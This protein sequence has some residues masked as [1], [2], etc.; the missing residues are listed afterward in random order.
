MADASGFFVGL[1]GIANLAAGIADRHADSAPETDYTRKNEHSADKQQGAEP[2]S[3]PSPIH[4]KALIKLPCA[5]AGQRKIS[6]RTPRTPRRVSCAATATP[7]APAGRP[8]SPSKPPT[9]DGSG[10]P[11]NRRARSRARGAGSLPSAGPAPF[12]AAAAPARNHA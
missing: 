8:R 7:P 10:I 4:L 2:A 5:D 9:A 6:F 3:R 1:F 11:T 12:R